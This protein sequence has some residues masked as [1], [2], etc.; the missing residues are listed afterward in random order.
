MDFDYDFDYDILDACA[1]LGLEVDKY[2]R[3]LC[4]FHNETKASLQLY[5]DSHSFYCFGCG[6]W[7]DAVYLV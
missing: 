5:L 3:V 4:P 2:A 7:G 1:R 6:A